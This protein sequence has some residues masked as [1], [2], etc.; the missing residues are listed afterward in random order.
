M[1]AYQRGRCEVS[2]KSCLGFAEPSFVAYYS[3]EVVQLL[4]R[5]SG[6]SNCLYRSIMTFLPAPNPLLT[7]ELVPPPSGDDPMGDGL[8]RPSREPSSSTSLQGGGGAISGLGTDSVGRVFGSIRWSL[9][10]LFNRLFAH[11]C[12]SC[13][14]CIVA[15]RTS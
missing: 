7:S 14:S 1:P 12:T 4:Q 9:G 8:S 2:W 15:G 13:S 6:G 3:T 10:P 11:R 5:L